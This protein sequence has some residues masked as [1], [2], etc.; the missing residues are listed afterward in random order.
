M[1][2]TLLRQSLAACQRVDV[3]AAAEV[4]GEPD[5]GSSASRSQ[6]QVGEEV[7]EHLLFVDRDAACPHRRGEVVVPDG[8][9]GRPVSAGPPGA[10][11]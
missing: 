8:R 9:D 10:P 5:G 2:V 1:V 4:G 3:T 11:R 7:V 6:V